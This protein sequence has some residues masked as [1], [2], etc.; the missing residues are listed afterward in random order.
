MAYSIEELTN[1]IHSL[2]RDLQ[3]C[4]NHERAELKRSL[5]YF[6]A[7]RQKLSPFEGIT[8]VA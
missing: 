3:T 5:K 2:R 8:L 7:E 6:M 1:I 4:A